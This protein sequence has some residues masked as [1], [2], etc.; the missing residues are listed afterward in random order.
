MGRV[1][2]IRCASGADFGGSGR[3]QLFGERG[4][5]GF[6]KGQ[7]RETKAVQFRQET[8]QARLVLKYGSPF[9]ETGRIIG[10]AL[11]ND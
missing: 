8:F 4:S 7:T 3:I 11:E 6:R 10:V 9:W 2:A 1:N 5:L